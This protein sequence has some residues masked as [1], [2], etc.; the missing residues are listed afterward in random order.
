MNQQDQP[1]ARIRFSTGALPSHLVCESSC[2]DSTTPNI[3][4]SSQAIGTLNEED[5]SSPFS[6]LAPIIEKSLAKIKIEELFHY[7]SPKG[8]ESLCRAIADLYNKTVSRNG[9][10][11]HESY[12]QQ[13]SSFGAHSQQLVDRMSIHAEHV[14]ITSSAQ[15][16][17]NIVFSALFN[18]RMAGYHTS[19]QDNH[20]YSSE[21][22]LFLQQP[23]FFGT[24]RLVK[25]FCLSATRVSNNREESVNSVKVESFETVEELVRKLTRIP[26]S[27][28]TTGECTS[29]TCNMT[30][31]T[32]QHRPRIVIYICSNY[33]AYNGT[34]VSDSEKQLLSLLIKSRREDF[35]FI[36]IEDNPYD[37]L[38]LS[39]TE[40]PL[41][42]FEMLPNHTILIGGFSKI[43]APGI[44]TGYIILD[45]EQQNSEGGKNDKHSLKGLIH[46]EK[47]DQ[48]LFTSTLCQQVCTAAISEDGG[49]YLNSW[50]RV[51]KERRNAT[52][53]YL[54]EFFHDVKNHV[55]WTQAD[56]GIFI[57]VRFKNVSKNI[58]NSKNEHTVE[59]EKNTPDDISQLL[60]IASSRYKLDLEPSCYTYLDGKSRLETRVNFILPQ[61][62]NLL[63]E[64]ISRLRQAYNEWMNSN[65]PLLKQIPLSN[66]QLRII[67]TS[68]GTAVPI[69]TVRYISNSSMGTTGAQIA[70]EC[71]DRGHLVH[72]LHSK[73]SRVPNEF[74]PK[75]KSNLHK[76]VYFTFDEYHEQLKNLV[77][78][79]QPDVVILSAAVS[80]YGVEN[81]HND[82]MSSDLE[83][84]TLT[85]VKL[86]KIISL[87]KK[88]NP[89]VFL[90]GFKLLTGVQTV[91]ELINT[92]YRHGIKNHSNLTVAN[93][94]LTS[95]SSNFANRIITLITPEKSVIPCSLKN[96]SSILVTNIEK[97]VS[98][99]HY[100]TIVHKEG[101]VTYFD[102]VK[103][104][105]QTLSKMFENMKK[106]YTLGLFDKYF[107]D[108]GEEDLSTSKNCVDNSKH[109][110]VLDEDENSSAHFGFVAMRAPRPYSGFLITSRASNK[111]NPTLKDIV[112]VSNADFGK[113]ELHVH[114]QQ[115]QKSSLNANVAAWLF[116]NR[117][118]VNLILHAHIF[119]SCDNMT[120]F[121]YSPGTQE[122]VDAVAEKMTHGEK[123]VEIPQHGIISVSESD[124]IE[125][126]I[127]SLGEGHA[128]FKFAHLYDMIYA[129]FQRST[130]LI[131]V[132][133]R[134]FPD[135][136]EHTNICDL[137]CGT[138]EVTR[139]L[140][141][142]GFRTFTLADQ[143][144]KM[145]SYA[146]KKLSTCY[147]EEF[148]R[149]IPTHVTS[150]QELNLKGSHFDVIVMR[151]AI[152]YAMNL[153]GL[154]MVFA[155]CYEHLKK[156]G[157]LILNTTNFQVDQAEKF[158]KMRVLRY[159]CTD[160]YVGLVGKRD[161]RDNDNT[162]Q[163]CT[164]SNIP[165]N[166]YI[167]EGN[168]LNIEN[169]PNSKHPRKETRL[170]IHAQHCVMER[171]R[172]DQH[173]KEVPLYER[174]CLFDLN[175]FG[176]FTRK[177]FHDE[178]K[179]A[180]FEH[181]KCYGKGL[182]EINLEDNAL[183]SS[184]D[185]L[186]SPSLYFV[187][188][189]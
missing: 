97:R 129:R 177:E 42:L 43:L 45:Q 166:V 143:S 22:I 98:H 62:L 12:Q 176:M 142:R 74:D 89:K 183:N 161:E 123:I 147:G 172:L 108:E 72:F 18:N 91:K 64:G 126:A 75:H 4:R 107:D 37:F 17:L 99:K 116:E 52:L 145:L 83:T 112:Y 8:E 159:D 185:E 134:E 158:S 128:Y 87:V 86:P 33:Q 188:I 127:H 156:G 179:Q 184:K 6:G 85:L 96:L 170:L 67:I 60:K 111:L 46:R 139:L 71:L 66:K 9:V 186:K 59:K 27:N 180:G 36:I 14:H 23:C 148:C 76:H 34:R 105:P 178:L 94:T 109:R 152:N 189:K 88:W 7:G 110:N 121:D 20:E 93:S 103:E 61:S 187:A 155:S 113:R 41:T 49:A 5:H 13:R 131:D 51:V 167:R 181:V 174:H 122:D 95:D 92:A 50:R 19:D 29:R 63:R 162:V 90:V 125:E 163:Q 102:C 32:T 56:C 40:R 135:N 146:K 70:N 132:L 117:K 38:Y 11:D 154:S 39:D 150:M 120:D 164:H 44:R 130:D 175:K 144:D 82:K 149:N 80:D 30:R 165:F 141:E 2:S 84:Q 118:E 100:K 77:T 138:G 10:E 28:T 157:K 3:V 119:P 53:Q 47:L 24:V 78:T 25:K 35:E 73:A 16:A 69:D 133:D 48:D 1:T 169:N 21:T 182:E 104:M 114:S 168:L 173:S 15:Q 68:G 55:E 57:Y 26:V 136:K 171:V 81:K 115:G 124:N 31:K 65:I 153:E 151:Q 101:D 79:T 137:C 160:G 58:N 106:A 140:Y 54:N